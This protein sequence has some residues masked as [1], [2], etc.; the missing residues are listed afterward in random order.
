MGLTLRRR[1]F[2]ALSVAGVAGL[3]L[4]KVGGRALLGVT[5]P[6]RVRSYTH[7]SARQAAT[8]T[9]AGLAFV[10]PAGDAAYSAGDWDP[11]EGMDQMLALLAPDQ[12]GQIGMAVLLLEEWT[13]G[14]SGFSSWSRDAQLALLASWRTSSL[15]LH[16]TIWGLLHAATCSTFSGTEAGWVV[17]DY[18]GPCVGAGRPPGQTAA[19]EWDEIVP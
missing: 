5:P 12:R 10:G 2:L 17:M 18:P 16:R 3:A 1:D 9:A 11:A 15:A 13:L 14:L 19:F 7:L 8:I 4:L 6:K